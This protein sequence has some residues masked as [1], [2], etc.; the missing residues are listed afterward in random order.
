LNGLAPIQPIVAVRFF[1][2]FG[3]FKEKPFTSR[4]SM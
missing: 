2:L 4:I 1:A 3:V